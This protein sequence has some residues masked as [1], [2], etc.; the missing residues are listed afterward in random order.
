MLLEISPR[1]FPGGGE[2]KKEAWDGVK[3]GSSQFLT[4]GVRTT[5]Y[6][7]RTDRVGF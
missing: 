6:D 7:T 2:K 1:E 4:D 3:Q 5:F